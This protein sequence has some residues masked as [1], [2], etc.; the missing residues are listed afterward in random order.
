MSSIDSTLAI[1]QAGSGLALSTFIALHVS[2]HALS[3]VSFSLSNNALLLIRHYAQNPVVEPLV[4]LGAAVVHITAGAGRAIVRALTGKGKSGGDGSWSTKGMPKS[5]GLAKRELQYQRLS[6]HA[7]IIMYIGHYMD[8][9]GRP[10]IAFSDPEVVDLTMITHSISR[11][12]GKAVALAA[13]GTLAIYHMSYGISKSLRL[14]GI[15]KKASKPGL[16]LQVGGAGAVTM[17]LTMVAISGRGWYKVAIPKAKLWEEMEQVS[18][19]LM[20]QEIKR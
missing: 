17:G 3:I 14:L 5:L 7:L 20:A 19:E 12:P 16:Y 10:M 13:L 8:V 1:V 15:T 18:R 9:R 6:G 2:G 4:I 11:S